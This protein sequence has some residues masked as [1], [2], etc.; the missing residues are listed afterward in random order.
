MQLFRSLRARS[1]IGNH[2]QRL[3]AGRHARLRG[4]PGPKPGSSHADVAAQLDDADWAIL[5]SLPLWIDVPEHDVRVV[6]AGIVPGV[7]FEKQDPWLLTHIR[8]IDERGKPSEKWGTLWG[9]LYQERAAHRVW[10]QRTATPA[11]AP[12]RDRAR[13]RLRVRRRADCT[14]ACPMASPRRPS[15]LVSTRWCRCAHAAPT[16]TTVASYPEAECGSRLRLRPRAARRPSGKL[17]RVPL[18]GLEAGERKLDPKTAHY[19]CDVLRLRAGEKFIA[20]DPETKLEADARL[21]ESEHG[22]YCG[23]GALREGARVQRYGHR[24]RASARQGRQDRTSRARSDRTRRGRAALGRKCAQRLTR[25]TN[26]ARASARAGRRSRSMPRAN[27]V[28]QTC[29]RSSDRTRSSRSSARWRDQ[30]AIKLCLV[31]GA[32]QSLRA[33][34]AAWTVGSP[35]AILI[36]PEGGLAPEEVS[37]AEQAGFVAVSFGELVLR[38]EIAGTAVLGAL[39]LVAQS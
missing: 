25:R 38:T 16:P 20:F 4:E 28:A 10:T 17:T 24:A 33:L 19:L 29:P 26:A 1:A 14:G 36:G 39:L 8:S 15:R 37:E 23:I 34:T 2:E 35:I 21:G 30:N 32:A 9:S 31:P 13:Y 7:P 6:H 5:E 12:A 27:A 11:I 3:L 18:P 22:T